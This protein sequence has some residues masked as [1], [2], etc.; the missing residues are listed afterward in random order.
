MGC[1][2]HSAETALELGDRWPHARL[3]EVA[4]ELVGLDVLEDDAARLSDAG[5]DIRPGDARDFDLGRTFDL[6]VAGDLLEHLDDPGGFLA[7]VARHM[8]PGSLAVVT[9]PNPFSAEQLAWIA[10]RSKVLVNEQHTMWLDPLVAHELVARSPL[11]VVDFHWIDTRFRMP[12]T[13]GGPL[14]RLVNGATRRL[15]E[16]RPL[17]RRDFALVL[18]LAGGQ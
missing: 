5:Y 11:D 9:T 12:I 2:D 16:R 18:A 17:L 1:I 4:A 10:L 14:P 7:S 13:G 15:M 3:R 6:V 8:H